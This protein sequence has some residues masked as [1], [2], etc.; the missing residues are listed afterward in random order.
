M[1]GEVLRSSGMDQNTDA[2]GVVRLFML[3]CRW[4]PVDPTYQ[5]IQTPGVAEQV[6]AEAKGATESSNR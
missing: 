6:E 1:H 3:I 4:Q 2:G 5:S